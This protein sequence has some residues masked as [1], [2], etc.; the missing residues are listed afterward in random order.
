MQLPVGVDN[1]EIEERIIQHLAAAAAMGRARHG[2][3]RE[4]HRS[5]S[6]SQGHQQ[7]M[8]F[9][10]Q[11]NASSPPPHPPM[12][13]S[14]SQRDESDTVS[15]LP[16]NALGE[17]SHQSNT[18][19]PTSSHPRQVSPSASDSNSRSLPE[20][21][22]FI[23]SYYR[24]ITCSQSD[25]SFTLPYAGLLINLPQVNKIELDHQNSSHFR[26]HLSLD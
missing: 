22:P 8:V 16:H 4:G 14:P 26:N 12:P 23:V 1:A 20:L 6:S 2:V 19:P 13:S 3:R 10:S 7:F 21:S 15:N 5:R 24:V 9:S 17:G 11:P 25:A 18:Q